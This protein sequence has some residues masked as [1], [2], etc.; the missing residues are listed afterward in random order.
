MRAAFLDRDGTVIDDMHYG[1]SPELVRPLPGA[2]EALWMLRE[3]GFGVFVVT[4]QSG[5]ARG[6][7]SRERLHEINREMERRLGFRFTAIEFCPHRP[8]EQCPCR[9]PLVGMVSR[10]LRRWPN[11]DL[12]RSITVGDKPS[13]VL[14]GKNLGT[15]TALLGQ[16][17]PRG[18]EPD[19]VAPDL[20][21]VARW[22][23]GG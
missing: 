14:L 22:A 9:K 6:F 2:G 23:I 5:A 15:R 12:A 18:S 7:L 8:G 3:A 21:E 17:D 4:N 16:D 10:I 20:L 11:I 19:L 13:D 1:S